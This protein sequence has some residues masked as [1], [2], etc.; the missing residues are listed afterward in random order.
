MHK[1]SIPDYILQGV[2]LR[3]GTLHPFDKLTGAASALVVIDLQNAFM[4]SGMPAEGPYAREIV[5]NV[6][7]LAAAVRA[8]GGTVVWVKM[9]VQDETERWSVYFDHLMSPERRGRLLETLARGT[10]G[11]ALHADLN[12]EPADLT[13]EKKRYS[14]FIQGSSD[15]DGILRKLGIDTVIVAG[16][17]TNV[18]CESTARD[19]MMLNYKTVLVSD[20]NATRTDE[21]HN[22]TLASILQVFGDV[23]STDEV[24]TRLSPGS[25]AAAPRAAE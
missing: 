4:L 25:S 12:V 11:H 5:P 15:L 21:E 20:A 13:I 8:A 23:L 6:N 2:R 24:I 16:T 7:R 19:A 17:L 9:T 14:A 22:A 10:H 18:C 3:R 1:I